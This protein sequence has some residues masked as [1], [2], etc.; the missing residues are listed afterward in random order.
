MIEENGKFFRMFWYCWG[1]K[2]WL[3]NL[4]FK[5]IVISKIN[6]RGFLKYFLKYFNINLNYINYD[7]INLNNFLYFGFMKSKV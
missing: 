4:E 6:V 7:F 1:V 3:V 5:I 2:V